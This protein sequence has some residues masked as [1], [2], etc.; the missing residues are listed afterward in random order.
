MQAGEAAILKSLCSFAF[1]AK[2][3]T[4]EIWYSPGL[5]AAFEAIGFLK[6]EDPLS[7]KCNK[8]KDG[9]NLSF[10]KSSLSSFCILTAE[11]IIRTCVIAIY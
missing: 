6:P 10:N 8:L 11:E 2:G 9:L 3:I 7:K 1:Q 5:I 4:P